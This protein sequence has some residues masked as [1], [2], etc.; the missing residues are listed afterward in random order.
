MA[1]RTVTAAAAM[2]VGAVAAGVT[3]RVWWRTGCL[4]WGASAEEVA[5][6]MP[7]DELLT[8]PDLVATRAVS[9]AAE[10]DQIWPWLVQLGSG[11][12]GA[13]TYDWIENLFGLKMH[14]ANTILPEFQTLAVGDSF[15]LGARGPRMCARVVDPARALVFASDRGDWV[16]AFG[17]YPSAEGTRL[18]SRN[19]I[20][21]PGTSRAA[22][23][24]YSVVMGPASW[25]MER[26]MLLG[27]KRRAEQRAFQA[28]NAAA[29]TAGFGR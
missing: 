12:G 3:Y 2:A 9:I 21:A 28:S 13:Y 4:N 26:K 29:F 1:P 22:K 20:I 16:W 5:R 18:V 27:I 15:P 24:A 14:S 25:V 8:H 17:L 19:R 6:T 7:G 23:V 10:P 11:R